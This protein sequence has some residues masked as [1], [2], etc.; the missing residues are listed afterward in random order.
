MTLDSDH[1]PRF[2]GQQTPLRQHRLAVRRPLQ[3]PRHLRLFT[4]AL[5]L[6]ICLLVSKYKKR[7]EVLQEID[8][9]RAIENITLH[10][11]LPLTNNAPAC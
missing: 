4:L 11:V 10:K 5:S 7:H 6:Q 9:I 8:H 3:S 1:R 2:H